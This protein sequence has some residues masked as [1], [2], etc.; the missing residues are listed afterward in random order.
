[1]DIFN[2]PELADTEKVLIAEK[3]SDPLVQKYLGI[4]QANAAAD[5]VMSDQADNE[6]NEDY[7]RRLARAKGALDCLVSLRSIKP[8][9]AE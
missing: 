3:F 4:L 8:A 9:A 5:I 6:R 1:M 7:I 2:I